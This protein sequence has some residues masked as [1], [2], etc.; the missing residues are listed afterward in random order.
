M[1]RNRLRSGLL[2]AAA[3]V[4]LLL[5]AEFVLPKYVTRIVTRLYVDVSELID[6]GL[7]EEPFILPLDAILSNEFALQ[8]I[9]VPEAETIVAAG[10]LGPDAAG[11]LEVIDQD[12]TQVAGVDI[13][14]VLAEMG[15]SFAQDQIGGV[16]QVIEINGA[17]F[18]LLG[19][20]RDGCYFAALI[21]VARREVVDA[22]PCIDAPDE[23]ISLNILSGGYAVMDDATVLIGLGVGSDITWTAASAA[24]QDPASP[25]GKTLRYD[26]RQDA[27]GPRL[28]NRRVAT[29]GHRNA[30]GMVRIGDWV[31]AVEHGPRG[32]DEINI[33]ED[34]ANYGWPLFSAG[35]QYNQGDM[36]AF[37]PEGAGFQNPIFTFVPSIATSDISACPSIIAQ[38]YA[39][40]DCMIVSG[41]I[42][43]ALFIVLGD[44]AAQRIWSVERI[45]VGAR[46]REVFVHDDTL[47]LV[48]DR[49]TVLRVDIVA[50]P[51][52]AQAGPCGDAP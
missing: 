10:V 1:T 49:A 18:V 31:V 39:E 6:D 47:Y 38:R 33:I 43:E 3:L 16:K 44:L 36:P 26:I 22:F 12:T 21:D 20:Q 42:S 25:Y 5:I 15:A 7:I 52:A 9:A 17:V 34:G 30:Q 45:D 11:R 37:A 13:S 35:S 28:L 14:P 46:V 50:L 29:L 48:P 2:K 40:A 8:L 4:T 41:L 23:H 24:A 19:L 51:C 27:D 32:G